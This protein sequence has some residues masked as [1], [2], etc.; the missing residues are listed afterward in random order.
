V[1]RSYMLLYNCRLDM[2]YE[3]LRQIYAKFSS[4]PELWKV[5]VAQLDFLL[6]G[7]RLHTAL[8]LVEDLIVGKDIRLEMVIVIILH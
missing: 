6:R 3:A 8:A 5:S 7:K 2:A 1:C 4:L